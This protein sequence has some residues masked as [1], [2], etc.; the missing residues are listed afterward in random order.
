LLIDGSNLQSVPL[1]RVHFGIIYK[2]RH[3]TA[4]HFAA[5]RFWYPCYTDEGQ[6][7]HIGEILQMFGGQ[8]QLLN[9]K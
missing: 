1:Y 8:V 9:T 6:C 2:Q 3:S 5:G 7:R 4:A